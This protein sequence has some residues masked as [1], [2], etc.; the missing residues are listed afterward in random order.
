M[1]CQY[2]QFSSSPNG[3]TSPSE[4]TSMKLGP[5]GYFST[6]P[7]GI[8]GLPQ[9]PRQKGRPRKRKPKDIEAMTANLGNWFK[10][11]AYNNYF[12]FC[13]FF[14]C[15]FVFVFLVCVVIEVGWCDAKSY[16]WRNNTPSTIT[17]Y[18]RPVPLTKSFIRKIKVFIAT[19]A[20]LNDQTHYK[21]KKRMH[22]FF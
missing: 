14:R 7:H 9:A 10:S 19:T 22:I 16:N 20:N 12:I 5:G 3:Q 17:T 1:S 13:F 2:S 4:N 6:A 18:I 15:F 8:P 11:L 21:T